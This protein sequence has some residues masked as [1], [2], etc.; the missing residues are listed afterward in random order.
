M[1][2]LL[3]ELSKRS[4]ASRGHLSPLS[5]ITCEIAMLG[6]RGLNLNDSEKKHTLQS[7]PGYFSGL[8]LLC[9]QYVG[10]QILDPTIDVGID[11][12]AEYQAAL[13]IHSG[14]R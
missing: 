11:L 1:E 4:K 12:S 9:L 3:D 7:L 14:S 5:P 10:F 6:S 8:H 13:E 2:N